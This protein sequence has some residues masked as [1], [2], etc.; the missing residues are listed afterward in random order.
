MADELLQKNEMDM[1]RYQI[2]DALLS[3]RL[4]ERSIIVNLRDA[5]TQADAELARISDTRCKVFPKPKR[6]LAAVTPTMPS[7]EWKIIRDC[8]S[9]SI[10]PR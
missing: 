6:F 8:K 5:Y 2:A 7:L 10:R 1:R 4:A 3:R 9:R